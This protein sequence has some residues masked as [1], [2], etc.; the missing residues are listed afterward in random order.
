MLTSSP[1]QLNHRQFNLVRLSLV[2]CWLA[3]MVAAKVLALAFPYVLVTVFL[4]I[5]AAM[6]GLASLISIRE[7]THTFPNDIAFFSLL[8]DEFLFTI[9]LYFTGGWTNPLVTLYLIT[10]TMAATT[11][12]RSATLWIA[13]VAIAGYTVVSQFYVPV[14]TLAETLHAHSHHADMS[15]FSLHIAGMWLT[16]VISAFTIAIFVSNLAAAR[17]E[18]ESRLA[19]SRE[20]I[21]RNESVIG[22]ASLAAGTAHELGTPLST[23]TVITSEILA[24]LK[25]P[26]CHMETQRQGFIED[27]QEQ[28]NQLR[29]CKSILG[30]LTERANRIHSAPTEKL[31]LKAFID[32]VIDQ[33]RLLH[34][35]GLLIFTWKPEHLTSAPE[36][37]FEESLGLAIHNLLDNAYKVSP[38][39]IECQCGWDNEQL[40]LTILDQGP[41]LTRELKRAISLEHTQ[42]PNAN[43]VDTHQ[44][45]GIGLLLVN[46]T[47]ESLGGQ[48]RFFNRDGGGAQVTLTIPLRM[49]VD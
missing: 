33:W 16:F 29:L 37:R 6:I 18:T 40:R 20:R 32:S 3:V 4:F 28:M 8:L 35:A 27:L 9:L 34:P 26:A 25:D 19:Q 36:I 39:S 2:V 12:P 42:T 47:V 10:I 45:L 30:K 13:L 11:L 1:K 7:E 43:E 22:I 49:L 21:L 15:G 46:A 41:G 38:I 17:R 14:N 48:V 31:S 23:M 24:D 5:H 44:G